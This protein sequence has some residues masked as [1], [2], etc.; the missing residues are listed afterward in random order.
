MYQGCILQL[1]KPIWQVQTAQQLHDYLHIEGPLPKLL[2]PRP[3]LVGHGGRGEHS[4][5]IIQYE[6]DLIYKNKSVVFEKL[7]HSETF[8]LTSSERCCWILNVNN[9]T[10]RYH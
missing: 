5:V 9:V 6:R 7:P 2:Q 10:R 4:R 1:G 8:L 3:I